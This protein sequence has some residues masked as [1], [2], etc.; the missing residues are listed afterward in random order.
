M[1]LAMLALACA[2]VCAAPARAADLNLETLDG[3]TAVKLMDEGKLTSVELTRAYIA[4]IAA[5]NKSGPGLNAVSQL[6]P[7]ALQ[8]AALLDKERKEGHVRGPAHGLP[9]LLKD[10]IDVKGMYTSAGNY[11]LRNSFPA[12]DS[13]VAKKLRENG[14]VIL[15]KLGLS[16]YANFFGN[17]PSGF[18]NLTGQVLNAVDADQN[19]SGSSSGSGSA[20]AAALSALT[21]GTETSGSI[22]SPS[23]ANGLV[24][25]RPTV[26][27]VPGYGI[28]PISASQDTAGPMDRTV[29]NAAM[30]LQSIA[31]PDP[32]N[33]DY[34]RGIWGPGINDADIIPPVPATVPNYMSALDLNF[35]RGKRIGWNGTSAE[36]NT[37]KAA[38]AAAGAI[39][40]ERP[41][42][43]PAGIGGSV[44]NYEAH[45]DI[46]HYYAHLG[47]DAPI[48]SLQ[49]E[50]DDNFA[51]EH[52][53]LKFGNSTH[54]AALAIDVSPLSAASIAYRETL[55]TGKI[56]SHQ[57]IDRMMQNDTPADPS[58]DF[59]AILG[60]VSNGPRAG[61]PQL[62]IPMGYSTT[63]RRTLNVSIHA[64]A[65]KERDLIGVAYVIEQAT[66]L[67][68][69]A[70]E[71]NP[72]MYRC[73]HTVP[74]PAFSERG[75]CNPDYES[76]MKL[77]GGAAPT[78]PFSLETE[79]VKSLQ[80]R[81]TAGTLNAETLTKAYLA[82]IAATN[83]EGPALQAVRAL[84][85][86]A[87]EEAKLLDRERATSGSRGPLHGIPVLL[88]DVIDVS[89]LP[90]TAG[91]IALQKS[92]PNSDAALVA[93]LKAAGA[94]ILGK[95]N[96]SELNGLLDGNAPEGYS[97]LGGQVL[98]PSDTDKTPAGSAAGSAAATA[99]GL[100]ALTVGLETSTDSAQIIAP[101]GV[102]GV[103]A[104]KPTVGLVSSDGVLPVAKSQDAAGPITRTVADAATGLS[105]LTGT[106][107]TVAPGGLTGKRVAVVGAP[108]ASVLTAITGLGATTVTKTAGTTTAASIINR[109]FEK[110]LNA[111]LGG[112]SGGA[113]SLQ[114]IVNYNTA[115][116]VEGLKYQQG[117]LVGALSPDLSALAA[118]TAAGK[119]QSAGVLD[120]LLSDTDVIL[121]PSGS[122]LVNI[123]DRAGYPVLTVPAAYGT[124]GSGRNPIGVSFI[125]KANGEAALLNSG[126][127]FEQATNVR[128]AP[129]DTN[130]SMFRCV[131]GSF[132]FSPH[133]CHPGDLLSPTANGP[134]ETPVA[135]DVGGSVPATLSLVLGTP[136]ATFGAF[137]PGV[138]KDYTANTTATVIST[139]GDAALSVS[140]PGHLMNGTFSLPSPLAVS[141]SKAA[142]TGPVS[143]ELVTV[144][145][146]QHIDSTDALR[147]GAYSKTLTFTLST[148]TP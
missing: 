122:T 86:H 144:T 27:L 36:V 90:T 129:S 121:V 104:L 88:D 54:A 76:T 103:V 100:A 19:P 138:T 21:I 10:L 112:T 74:A 61:Y 145:F 109:S 7:T 4:R 135:G 52:E 118:D 77:V 65:Y 95:T 83:A 69:P 68:K 107:Y 63:T 64:N 85:T 60:S 82:R 114:G 124:G 101:A 94:I 13:G 50:N 45:R 20:G 75:S 72:S 5:L 48:K 140:D 123:A 40:V 11:S 42:I 93:K 84:N 43:S 66:K 115:N 16:E 134:V 141:F 131:P 70:S 53:A 55:L 128:K 39:L 148:T 102:A 96:V 71:V 108:P 12:I 25:L 17:Q 28:A 143:N 56:L 119:S 79:S 34:Y 67:R 81:M 111:Y 9:I 22:I 105:A 18:S 6:N 26:G 142:W 110:D 130:P 97:A 62:T 98:L 30:T 2:L 35:V 23:Q 137:T 89:G 106:A 136:A 147:T 87:I 113:G 78:L 80:D 46:D 58:D 146:K 91:S 133:H 47:P 14:V 99:S 3:P 126:Y 33:A 31:G 132:F 51:N 116:P 38:L 73:A 8:D 139:A 41:V 127:A 117:Q 92:M 125:G 1:K 15:G 24:G 44:L 49:Q 120:T 32:H 59:I 37:A 57:G 29:A